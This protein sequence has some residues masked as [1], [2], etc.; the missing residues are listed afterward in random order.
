MASILSIYLIYDI[1]T[2]QSNSFDLL[3]YSSLSISIT[4]ESEEEKEDVDDDSDD[5]FD[6]DEYEVTLG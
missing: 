4:K 1:Q 2:M 3:L 6:V 5:D